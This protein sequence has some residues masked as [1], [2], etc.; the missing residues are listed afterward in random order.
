MLRG[1]GEKRQLFVTHSKRTHH[2]HISSTGDPSGSASS[3]CHGSCNSRSL[4]VVSP[5]RFQQQLEGMSSSSLFSDAEHRSKSDHHAHSQ[6]H[7]MSRSSRGKRSMP[8]VVCLRE[9]IRTQGGRRN[10]RL[11]T[12]MGRRTLS[13]SNASVAD[14]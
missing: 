10:G 14:V 2:H 11:S 9:S 4:E 3:C 5:E 13:E 8:I 6:T 12:C 7:R 1:A